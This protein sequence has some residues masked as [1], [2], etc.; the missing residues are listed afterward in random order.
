MSRTVA[1]RGDRPVTDADLA[2][3]ILTTG[4]ED[5]RETVYHY[6]LRKE[7]ADQARAAGL[8]PDPDAV[9]TRLA[10]LTGLEGFSAMLAVMEIDADRFAREL[11]DEE[12]VAVW[13]GDEEPVA[14]EG[15]EELFEREYRAA[16]KG[17]GIRVRH[18]LIESPHGGEGGRRRIEAIAAEET[19][20]AV[21]A[22]R[23]SACP[24]AAG[25]GIWG[26]STGSR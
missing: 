3:E 8:A 5:M 11:A 9:A 19:P 12:L 7:L 21:K 4:G 2:F 26:G 23:Y 13:L 1:W 10:A 6:L 22:A 15:V 25:G 16:L 20:F 14:E 24:S 18:I 17:E